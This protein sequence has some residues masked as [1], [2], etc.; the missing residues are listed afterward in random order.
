MSTRLEDLD[1]NQSY[2][3]LDYLTW[4]FKERV[5]LLRGRLVSMSPAPGR[6]HQEV[7]RNVLVAMA[8]FLKGRPCK[9]YDAPFDVVLSI[10]DNNTVVQPDICVIC[11]SEKLTE[12]GCTG[13]PEL[14]VEILSPGN[15]K[16]ELKEKF[17]LYEEN[18]VLEYWIISLSDQSVIVYRLNENGRYIGSKPFVEGENVSSGVI[19]GFEITVAEIFAA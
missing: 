16:K 9:V 11:D 4:Q 15:A 3:Y 6:M 10:K 8:V 13:A 1:L 2:T 18:G 7:S 17:E 19:Q 12:R 5:E 14:I